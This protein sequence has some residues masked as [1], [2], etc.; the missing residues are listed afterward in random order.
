[1][2]KIRTGTGTIAEAFEYDAL[3]RL[4]E[5]ERVSDGYFMT[6]SY[7]ASGNRRFRGAAAGASDFYFSDGVERHGSQR[8]RRVPGG[9][10]DTPVAQ[11]NETTVVGLFRDAGNSVS[12]ASTGSG[13]VLRRSYDAFGTVATTTGTL[14]MER[15]FAG[16]T[17]EGQS[18]LLYA[19]ARHYDP[20]FGR[21]LQRDPLGFASDQLYAYAANNPY[22]FH[23]PTGL[24]WR[25]LN[26]ERGG[27]RTLVGL[28]LGAAG[29]AGVN[30]VVLAA[31]TATGACP[32]I[33]LVAA[34]AILKHEAENGFAGV[35]E[36]VESARRT[37]SGDATLA[38]A[39]S[40]G[41]VAGGVVEGIIRAVAARM[42]A[43]AAAKSVESVEI[44]ESAAADE[45]PKLIGTP[46]DRLL[47]E[48]SD[49]RLRDAI[50]N[51]YRPGAKV[52]SGSS[53][54]AYRHEQ[55]TGELLSRAGH[56]QKLLDRRTQLLE[57]YHDPKVS[58]ADRAV[59]KE[60][61]TDVQSALSGN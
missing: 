27:V 17:A 8:V 40:V 51:L 4:T 16:L 19:R 33:A 1:M 21:F 52:R 56:G 34:A 20:R 49:P 15:G 55:A 22:R 24:F 31:C 5:Y 53:M 18:P 25:S 2:T 7:D 46:R 44:V 60:L 11:I 28:G 14:P 45:A 36:L 38:E 57:I 41:F 47:R 10:G 59:A 35:Y 48:A 12:A 26:D 37:L 6:L 32:A 29:A 43:R 30:A 39:A 61:L 42:A 3:D 23:D 54:D 13:I 9:S 50:D 58:P